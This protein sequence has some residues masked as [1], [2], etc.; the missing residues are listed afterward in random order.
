MRRRHETRG[1][2]IRRY[3]EG[4]GIRVLPISASRQER[5]R[6]VIYG[7]A[8]HVS[9][10][11]RSDEDRLTTALKCIQASNARA[12]HSDIIIAVYDYIGVHMADVDRSEAIRAFR[13]I[14][15]GEIRMR[16]LKLAGGIVARR[17]AVMILIA[18]RLERQKEKAA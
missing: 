7:R 18:D 5:G 12:L 16:A 11:L 9:R 17:K 13:G 15:L 10:L 6:N 8:R 4:L 2:N 14:D 3:L 1:P